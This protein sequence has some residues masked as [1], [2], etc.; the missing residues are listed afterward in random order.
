MSNKANGNVQ[1]FGSLRPDPPRQRPQDP[2]EAIAENTG[3][4]ADRVDLPAYSKSETLDFTVAANQRVIH[5]DNQKINAMLIQV[6][7]GTLFLWFGDRQG[8][9]VAPHL[10]FEVKAELGP[11]QIALSPLPYTFTISGA[12]AVATGAVTLQAL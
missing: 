3:R 10:V 8:S 11:V 2:L 4:L 9:T 5:S 6:Q 7:S 1:A 12:G